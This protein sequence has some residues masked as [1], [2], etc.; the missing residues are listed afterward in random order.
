MEVQASKGGRDQ[1]AVGPRGLQISS[2]RVAMCARPCSRRHRTDYRSGSTTTSCLPG[3]AREAAKSTDHLNICGNDRAALPC[4][5]PGGLDYSSFAAGSLA[6]REWVRE[7]RRIV[8]WTGGASAVRY[9][10]C[11]RTYAPTPPPPGGGV[12]YVFRT[13]QIRP[14]AYGCRTLPAALV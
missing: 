14:C 9:T 6:V 7:L 5:F 3:V 8:C 10:A 2:A 12:M 13:G 1:E 11:P 4:R